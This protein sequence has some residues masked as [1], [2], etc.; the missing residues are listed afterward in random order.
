[1]LSVASVRVSDT[2]SLVGA[3]FKVNC[4]RAVASPKAEV[5]P[6]KESLAAL[7]ASTEARDLS[8]ERFPRQ[9]NDR[10]AKAK[11]QYHVVCAY[12]LLYS[13]RTGQARSCVCNS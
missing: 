10:T 7:F 11:H 8:L 4:I 5:L 12:V 9:E 2:G 6:F 3:Y 1:M 13:L